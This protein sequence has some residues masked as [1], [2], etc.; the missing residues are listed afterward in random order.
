M[1]A[2]VFTSDEA[3]VGKQCTGFWRSEGHKWGDL[4]A[5]R[6]LEWESEFCVLESPLLCWQGSSLCLGLM[7]EVL[8]YNLMAVWFQWKYG[9]SCKKDKPH[10]PRIQPGNFL[11]SL[12]SAVVQKAFC[13][14]TQSCFRWVRP[15]SLF[16][17]II[18]VS[19]ARRQVVGDLGV[20]K[21]GWICSLGVFCLCFSQ[22]YQ[23]SYKESQEQT[24]CRCCQDRWGFVETGCFQGL[25]SPSQL[26]KSRVEA[27]KSDP[28]SS[29]FF[30]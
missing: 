15:Q 27:W 25:N 30:F 3:E 11:I 26:S 18:A 24:V 16:G 23:W 19:W 20:S 7:S 17:Y 8:L 13:S 28:I 21:E 9:L 14:W 29:T 12:L 10:N 5:W 1:S 2:P 22:L 4:V 6:F